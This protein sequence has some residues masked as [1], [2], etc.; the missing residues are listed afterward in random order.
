[1]NDDHRIAIANTQCSTAV[2]R[3][4]TVQRRFSGRGPKGQALRHL[5]F[6]VVD[7]PTTLLDCGMSRIANLKDLSLVSDSPIP[8]ARKS[9]DALNC[10]TNHRHQ[11]LIGLMPMALRAEPQCCTVHNI[12]KV[13]RD[14]KKIRV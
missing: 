3:Y 7:G 4:R 14:N 11:C 2:T 10:E 12:H 8:L 13:E 1:M 9:S 5:P 6:P